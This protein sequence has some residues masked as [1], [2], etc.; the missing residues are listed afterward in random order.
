MPLLPLPIDYNLVRQTLVQ[1]VAQGTGLD[2]GAVIMFEPEAVTAPRPPRPYMGLQITSA[3]MKMGWD[4]Q[5]PL[6]D[7][8][9]APTSLFRY[10]GP[11]SMSVSFEAYGRSHEEA[12]G[13]M[14]LWQGAL[15]QPPTQDVLTLANLAV[16]NVGAVADLSSLL[17]TAYEGRAQLDVSFGLT[18][19]AVVDLGRID[20]V[21]VSGDVFV[22]G[23]PTVHL[24]FIVSKG[25]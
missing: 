20:S 4:A 23:Q 21:P 24:N 6:T 22:D 19:N 12:Y 17:N 13:I 5:M 11:R 3:S 2:A 16:A 1:A 25:A 8:P 9:G 18:A 14:A 15:D 7:A 10:T